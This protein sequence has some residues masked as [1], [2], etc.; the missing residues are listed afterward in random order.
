MNV[1][2]HINYWVTTA[3]HDLPVAENLFQSGHYDWC[4]YIGI[5]FSKKY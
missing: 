2:K 3:E 1:K 4:L 5:S